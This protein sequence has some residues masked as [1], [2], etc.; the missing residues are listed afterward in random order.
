MA[1]GDMEAKLKNR[2]D[3]KG[4]GPALEAKLRAAQAEL[5]RREDL[6]AA[7]RRGIATTEQEASLNQSR[8]DVKQ[9]ISTSTS[10]TNDDN[11]ITKPKA[12]TAPL[13]P[14]AEEEDEVTQLKQ[15]GNE[16][17]QQEEYEEAIYL[18]TEA[19]AAAAGDSSGK[20]AL[21]EAC[22]ALLNNRALAHLR[23]QQWTAA[24]ADASRATVLRPGWAKPHYRLA[25]A[26]CELGSYQQAVESCRRG[27]ALLEAAGDRSKEFAPLLDKVAQVAALH[28]SLAGFDGSLLEVRSAGEEAWLGK[29]APA[30][31]LI[32]MQDD[33]EMSTLSILEHPT[34][35]LTGPPT[36]NALVEAANLAVAQVQQ[37]KA[38]VESGEKRRSYRSLKLAMKAAKDGDQIVL[39]RGIHNMAGQ[40]VDVDKRVIIRGEG[41]LREASLD[42]RANSPSFRI[43]RTCVIQNIELDMSGFREGVLV[44]G[45]STVKPLIEHCTIRCSGDDAVNVKLKA[46]PTFRNCELIGRKCG[47][48]V[49]GDAR[50]EYIDCKINTCQEQGVRV[51]DSARPTF[52]RCHINGNLEEGVVVMDQGHAELA[53]CHI[54]DNKGPGI[55][56]SESGS[57]TMHGCWVKDNVGGIFLWDM[58]KAIMQKVHLNGGQSHALLADSD[59]RPRLRNCVVEGVIQATEVGWGGIRNSGNELYELEDPTVLPAEEGCFKFEA[60]KYTRK[61]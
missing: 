16:A 60:D 58:S 43:T 23:L 32:D 45:P 3:K 57:V 6:E 59:S 56:L 50:G 19:L 22:S 44:T 46:A 31:P 30:D 54:R 13:T 37:E 35:A 10:A 49:M 26:R 11:V 14:P 34:A 12:P 17:L 38:L 33:T 7:K 52:R 47:I 36:G 48:K 29:E 55:D 9:N 40:S 39:L 5:K 1:Q 20:A 4:S 53:E 2:W 28:G 61:Q 8:G 41:R 15:A 21:P 24:A 18:Y 51:H 42:Q 27:E 25:Q